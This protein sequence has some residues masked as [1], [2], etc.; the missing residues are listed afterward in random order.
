[1]TGVPAILD[2]IQSIAGKDIFTLSRLWAV[3]VLYIRSL[4]SAVQ[5]LV[6]S[7]IT[8]TC[9]PLLSPP[10]ASEWSIYA[11]IE[12]HWLALLI[13]QVSLILNTSEGHLSLSC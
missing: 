3:Y 7:I 10:L 6:R 2:T 9:H 8:F 1:M 4:L 12:L 5:N 11:G 13:M